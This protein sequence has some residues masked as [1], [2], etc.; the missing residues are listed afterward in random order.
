MKSRLI[1]NTELQLLLFII[2]FIIIKK[3]ASMLVTSCLN[4]SLLNHYIY[5]NYSNLYVYGKK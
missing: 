4:G 3:G 5:V 2:Q 1:T